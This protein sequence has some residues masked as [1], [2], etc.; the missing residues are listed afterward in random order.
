M[1]ILEQLAAA[2]RDQA[3]I[4]KETL[5]EEDMQ[6]RISEILSQP[7]F[8]QKYPENRFYRALS[9]KGLSLI[10]ECK[11]ASPS[12]GLICPDYNPAE[13]AA[14]YEQAGASAISVLCES[15][16]FQ[17]SL[18]DLKQVTQKVSIPVLRKDFITDPYQ[19]QEAFLAG[20]SA[21]L[22]IVSLLDIN[23]L[24]HLMAE[25]GR[26][27]LDALVECH[28]ESEI[29]RA[30]KAGAKIIGVNNR[31]L[32][33]FSVDFSRSLSMRNRVDSSVLFVCESGFKNHADIAKARKARADAV[34]I[35]EALMKAEDKKQKMKEL[36]AVAV[37][38]K[39][40]NNP[41][42]NSERP[43]IKFCGLR[44]EDDIRL[45]NE[46]KPDLAGFI[47]V[48]SS[49]RYVSFDEAAQL[50]QGLH[51]SI[52]KTAVLLNPSD[53]DCLKAASFC[54]LLQIHEPLD[55]KQIFR[56]KN[57]L[58]KPVIEAVAV[59][60][61]SDLSRADH[62][63]ADLVL[64]DAPNPGSGQSF[65]WRMLDQFE[66]PF[67]LAGGIDASNI[68]QALMLRNI[69]GVDLA[70]SIETDGRKD[71]AKAARIMEVFRKETDYE[72]KFS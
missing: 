10:C 68:P 69:A 2:A 62:S 38:E 37:Q 51:P 43:L 23:Q 19:I 15:S 21:V 60:D 27:H 25:A 40:S 26:L 50:A 49:K 41:V 30:L 53:E 24:N 18:Q 56:L 66:K 65:D 67:V 11:K 31:N 72:R 33:D 63:D 70:S 6:I 71:P 29:D 13:I 12:K 47:L 45:V 55:Q 14:D 28:D 52:Q 57:R 39:N 64:L 32:K 20:A 44:N 61:I 4:R 8:K 58:D 7:D 48:P 16:G 17:G 5:P 54:D 22:L 9:Q 46:L 3:N 59:K 42:L 35:G 34:L 1:N 36:L